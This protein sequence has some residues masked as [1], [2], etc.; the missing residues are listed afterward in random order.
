MSHKAA[1]LNNSNSV[2][3]TI[4]NV[5]PAFDARM[6]ALAK[7]RGV[8]LNTLL[9]DKLGAL[10]KPE[11]KKPKVYHDLDW[12]VG[13]M[14][15]QEVDE[16]EYNINQARQADRRQA[17]EEFR[18]SSNSSDDSDASGTSGVGTRQ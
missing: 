7:K 6:K 15:V 11:A 4:R 2:Q 16:L 10:P 9:L 1:S 17:E 12:M 18:N 8:S 5:P 3:Y 14:T 13:S